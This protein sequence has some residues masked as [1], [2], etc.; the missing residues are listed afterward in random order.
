MR[1][2][3]THNPTQRAVSPASTNQTPYL[4]FYMRADAVADDASAAAAVLASIPA[5][6][7]AEVEADNRMARTAVSTSASAPVFGGPP[8]GGGAREVG[9]GEEAKAV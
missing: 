6:L 5:A 1:M 3:W 8:G 7:R 2:S 4:L 9:L